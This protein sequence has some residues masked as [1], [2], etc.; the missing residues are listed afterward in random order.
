M[1][2]KIKQ[3]MALS[4]DVMA[5]F[6]D[7]DTGMLG[8][9]PGWSAYYVVATDEFGDDCVYL[10]AMSPE[11]GFGD[12]AGYGYTPDAYIK[13]IPRY[14][15]PECAN[16]MTVREFR[17]LSLEDYYCPVCGWRMPSQNTDEE[18]DYVE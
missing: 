18:A 10:G 14:I 17:S 11:E 12:V 13:L 7:S 6:K 4:D 2:Q 9:W 1:K 3:I 16:Y 5:V 8:A 15:C